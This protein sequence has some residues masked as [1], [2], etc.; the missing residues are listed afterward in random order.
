MSDGFEEI[1]GRSNAELAALA[2]ATRELIREVYPAV[3][4]VPWVK[5]GTIGYGVG[6]R[7][8]SEQFC[9]IAPQAKHVNLGFYYGSELPDPE[10]LLAGTGKLLRHIKLAT[11]ADLANPALRHLLEIASTHRM[12]TPPK[13]QP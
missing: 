13:E 5:Q 3:V 6:P 10:R 9:Y 7:K 11:P 2:R 1:V 4:E 8:M 12:P